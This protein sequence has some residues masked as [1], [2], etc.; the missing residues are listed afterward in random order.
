[1]HIRQMFNGLCVFQYLDDEEDE[2]RKKKP[3]RKLTSNASITRVR[4]SH[5]HTDATL[6]NMN[7]RT[8]LHLTHTITIKEGTF[9]AFYHFW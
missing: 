4:P 7:E 2:V 6:M 8:K 5:T 9:L 3:R 1:M